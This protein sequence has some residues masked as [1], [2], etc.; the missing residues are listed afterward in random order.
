MVA[1]T[2]APELIPEEA[3]GAGIGDTLLDLW[4]DASGSIPAAR[5]APDFVVTPTGEVIP[6]PEG[7]TGPYQTSNPGFQYNGGSGGNGL[8]NNV[9]D[10]RVM[11]PNAKNPTGYVNYGSRQADGGWQTVNPY[12]GDPVP[13]TDPWWHIP[14]GK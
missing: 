9:T 12:T 1:A 7:A 11:D 13:P 8:A 5:Q 6:V 3:E 2:L 14:L 4:R 10:V